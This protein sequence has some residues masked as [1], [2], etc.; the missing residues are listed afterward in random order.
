MEEILGLLKNSS[1]YLVI[2]AVFAYFLKVFIEKKIEGVTGRVEEIAR[3]SLEIKK[4]LREEERGE[5]TAFRVAV[6]KW[7]D[8][9]LTGLFD[10]SMLTGAEAK[11]SSLYARDKEL[12]LAVKLAIVRVCVYLRD[13]ELEDRLMSAVIKI[14]KTYYP[15]INES[16]P[17]LIDVQARLTPFQCNTAG[18]TEGDRQRNIELHEI[19]TGEIK[20]FSDNVLKR[21]PGIAEQMLE[22]KEI[23]NE[24]VYRP[25]KGTAINKD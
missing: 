1:P 24:Y 17:V 3:T 25:I 9:L 14:R 16:L 22:L 11:V 18:M 5:L 7:E 19:M 10:Y 12:F 21:W 4:D 6:E 23:I 20:K 13:K 8:F 15:L 2:A